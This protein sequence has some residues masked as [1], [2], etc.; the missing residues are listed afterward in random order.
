MTVKM[1]IKE[2]QKLPQDAE[3]CIY[4]WRKG[5]FHASE[6]PT[7]EGMES[8][9]GVD[10]LTDDIYSKPFAALSFE[11]DDYTDKGDPNYGA[12]IMNLE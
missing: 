1:L 2:L 4:D 5:L 6:E 10:Y 3:I 7:S 8:N 9:F 11:N 12:L